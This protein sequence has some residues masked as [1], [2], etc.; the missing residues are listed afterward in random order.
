MVSAS[1]IGRIAPR[2]DQQRH[3][4][5]AFRVAHRKLQRNAIE[6]RRIGQRH[7]AIGKIG[8]DVKCQFVAADRHRPAADQ[9]LIG[10][11]ERYPAEWI[12][13][14]FRDAAELNVRNWRK[15]DDLN[16]RFEEGK[17][18]KI[19]AILDKRRDWMTSRIKHM[20]EAAQNMLRAL[21]PNEVPKVGEA[22]SEQ[23]DLLIR[24]VGMIESEHGVQF[25]DTDPGMKKER[26][27]A[28]K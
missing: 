12:E 16:I 6:K 28:K 14:A 18:I 10:A 25:F 26:K 17:I 4:E 21:W 19:D 7:A 15:R 22:S 27:K 5:M 1:A 2:R 13:A 3:V 24:V 20:P 11:A 23:I 8:A 9:R